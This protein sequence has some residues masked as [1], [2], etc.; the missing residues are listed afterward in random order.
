[1]QEPA[2]P[3]EKVKSQPPDADMKPKAPA[4]DVGKVKTQKVRFRRKFSAPK[5]KKTMRTTTALKSAETIRRVKERE[6]G[7]KKRNYK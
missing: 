7:G 3:K 5:E 4:L 1:M 6:T 2:K